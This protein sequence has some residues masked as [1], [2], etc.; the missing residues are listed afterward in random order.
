MQGLFENFAEKDD[1]L[2][3]KESRKMQC[4]TNPVQMLEFPF[5][6]IKIS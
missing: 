4:R 1:I 6:I 3:R 5:E 2:A